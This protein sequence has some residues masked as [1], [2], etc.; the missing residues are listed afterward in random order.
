MK[1]QN[2]NLLN[3]LSKLK[4]KQYPMKTFKPYLV[5][6]NDEKIWKRPKKD[7]VVSSC[8]VVIYEVW[9]H[10]LLA[11]SFY[12]EQKWENKQK[13]F[14]Q[15][16]IRRQ[17]AGLEQQITKRVYH[18]V[19]GINWKVW[20]GSTDGGW[21][22]SNIDTFKFE[23][24]HSLY[25]GDYYNEVHYVNLW[26][27][28]I[29]YTMHR[30]SGA[31]Y[32]ENLKTINIFDYLLIFD[33]HPQM[34][35][36]SKME[37][38]GMV[39]HS[40][41]G[42]HWSKTGNEVFGLTKPQLKKLIELKSVYNYLDLIEFRK[43]VDDYIK[44]NVTD[45]QGVQVIRDK[46]ELKDLNIDMKDKLYNYLYSRSDYYLYIDYIKMINKLG[47]P[48]S[49]K[50]KYPSDLKKSHDDLVDK[51]EIIKSKKKDDAI[52]K[53]AK[54]FEKYQIDHD[55]LAIIV[56]D[57]STSLINESKNN[58]NCVRTYIDKVA[59]G[60]TMIFFIRKKNDIDKSFVTLELKNKNI[61]Q[62]YA[63]HNSQID[64]K[65]KEFIKYWS[66]K[67]KFKGVYTQ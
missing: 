51:I 36:I 48:L 57:N 27:D 6:W 16:E 41:K 13:V 24:T 45:Y 9:R 10:R 53:H 58:H 61:I 35:M 52:K 59:N 19:M 43:Y 23:C 25:F 50:N 14:K 3:S 47:I 1:K 29:K 18:P 20:T 12:I 60:T 56:A 2:Q 4:L 31:E 63:D 22:T 5:S 21:Q 28:V 67:F 40:Q 7:T 30:Y 55:N 17:V 26:Q 37:L 65:S 15:F 46:E 34:E 11:R 8:Y 64:D 49:S 42:M 44:F 62:A 32:Y 66:H 38:A 39:M 33:K 54:K